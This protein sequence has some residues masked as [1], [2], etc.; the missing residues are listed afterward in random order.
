[1][2]IRLGDGV[3]LKSSPA[4]AVTSIMSL[5]E[6][7]AGYVRELEDRALRAR[8]ELLDLVCDIPE[9]QKNAAGDEYLM[10]KLRELANVL[11]GKARAARV[12]SSAAR[13]TESGAQ[14]VPMV[15]EEGARAIRTSVKANP[16]AAGARVP[17]SR[18]NRG[19]PGKQ[20]PIAFEEIC[21]GGGSRNPKHATGSENGR[22][23]SRKKR[24]QPK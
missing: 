13:A 15:K 19:R 3:A 24:G 23:V 20:H 7:V 14:S 18:Q 21:A 11:E 16:P 1:M 10:R 8:V 12:M 9:L 17:E 5:A 2:K 4:T 6:T 22:L